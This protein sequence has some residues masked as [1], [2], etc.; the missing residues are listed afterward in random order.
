MYAEHFGERLYLHRGLAALFSWFRI[1]VYRIYIRVFLG[2]MKYLTD[3]STLVN[4]DVELIQIETSCTI[5]VN[6]DFVRKYAF[7]DNITSGIIVK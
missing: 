3:V 2:P 4:K 1:I 6:K 7:D 5:H